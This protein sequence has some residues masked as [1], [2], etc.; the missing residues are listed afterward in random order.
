M[1]PDFP[2]QL[3]DQAS[4]LVTGQRHQADVRRAVSAAYYALFHLLIRDTVVHW[5]TPRHRSRLERTFDHQRMKT[6]SANLLQNPPR[7]NSVPTPEEAVVRRKL[8]EVAE[9]FTDLQQARHRADYDL[10]EP[11]DPSDALILVEQAVAVFET[12]NQIRSTDLAQDYLY[13][14]LFKD[15][16]F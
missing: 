16:T 13:S 2:E 12:W 9:A 14:L 7:N 6:A 8:V 3:L 5:S 1:L 11:L 4:V 15:R 10:S